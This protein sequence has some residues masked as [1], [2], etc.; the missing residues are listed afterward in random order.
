VSRRSVLKAYSWIFLGA[1]L[2]FVAVPGWV[3]AAV[4]VVLGMLPG[5]VPLTGDV[6]TLWLGLTGSLM[7]LLCVLASRAGRDPSALWAWDL[8]LLSKG[9]SAALFAVFAAS[10]K[11][12][13][14]LAGTVVDGAIFLHLLALLPGA[15]R[16]CDAGE[17]WWRPRFPGFGGAGYEVWFLRANQPSTGEALWLRC[18][19]RAC[20][21]GGEAAFWYVLFDREGKKT[22]QGRWE[23]PVAGASL[24]GGEV[25]FRTKDGEFGRGSTRASGPGVSWDISWR[26]AGGSPPFSFVPSRLFR[27]GIAGTRYAAPASSARF[28][29]ELRLGE[30]LLKLE[31]AMGC[32]GHL[33]GRRMGDNWRWAHAVLPDGEG[34]WSVLE[35]LSAQAALGPLRTPRVTTAHLW[36]RGR[37]HSAAGL[38][39]GLRSATWP[40]G[41]GWGFRLRFDGFTAEGEC[42]PDPACTAVVEYADVDGSRLL[43]ANSKTGSMKVEL[44]G[45]EPA[46]LRCEAAAAVETVRRS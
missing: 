36:H 38:L 33:W 25:L 35:I 31:D 3:L 2:A 46:S 45:P 16:E 6:P 23:V 32:V 22:P 24:S 10:E 34:G 30:R 7:A 1:G 11:N 4:D 14:F 40:A 17:D 42:L 21:A 28:T 12:P 41:A 26:P 15:E 19:L 37:H 29:G 9:V 8:L 27:W 20:A 13:S 5:A 43:C 18:S 39:D 44:D